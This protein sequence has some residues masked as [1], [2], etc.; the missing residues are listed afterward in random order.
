MYKYGILVY[1]LCSD[2]YDRG[3]FLYTYPVQCMVIFQGYL[4]TCEE[5][6][7]GNYDMIISPNNRA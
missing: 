5:M 4:C 7:T 3:I 2:I 6:N 1:Q